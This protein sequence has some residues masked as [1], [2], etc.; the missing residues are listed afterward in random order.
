MD[1]RLGETLHDAVWVLESEMHSVQGTAFTLA[2]VGVVTC[3]HVVKEDTYAWKPGDPR[4]RRVEV[5]A[6]DERLD[7]A[8]IRVGDG[9]PGHALLAGNSNRVQVRDSVTILGFPNYN[10]GQSVQELPAL[11]RLR[12]SI[13]S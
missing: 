3:D 12:T 11:V 4:P 9:Q 13:S 5:L 7:L 6:R 10:P 1:A 2:D 8:I